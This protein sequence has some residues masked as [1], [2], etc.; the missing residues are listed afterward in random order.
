MNR[1]ARILLFFLLLIAGPALGQRG[2]ADTV[3]KP[4]VLGTV[5]T[6][7]SPVLQETRTL[8][9]YLPPSF[10]KDSAYPVIYLLDGSADEDFIHTAG[11]IQFLTMLGL[12]PETVLVGIANV[13]RRRDFTF[14]TTVAADKKDFPTTG[15]SARFINALARDLKPF[16]EKSYRIKGRGAIVGQSLGGLLAAEILLK[17]PG[18]FDDYI[19]VSPSLWWDKESLLRTKE[20]IPSGTMPPRTWIAVGKEGAQM[21]ADAK[22]LAALISRH[23]P[24]TMRHFFVPMPQEDH[25]T[26]LHNSLYRAFRT[27]YP[28]GD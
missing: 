28:K 9:I 1:K 14:P 23:A 26:I 19:I 21:E 12:M 13:D 11:I 7:W 25:L 8:N 17:N 5:R 24:D 22:S 16:I 18:M 4:F 27:L 15:G 2:A 10:S 3:A 6:V 20:T